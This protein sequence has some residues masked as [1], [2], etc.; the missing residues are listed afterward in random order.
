MKDETGN[1]ETFKNKYNETFRLPA[2]NEL[3]G[4][5]RH[6]DGTPSGTRDDSEMA[7]YL[8]MVDVSGF[9]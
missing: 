1:T 9:Y 8:E 2:Y 5:E 6:D 4:E 3:T 7:Q